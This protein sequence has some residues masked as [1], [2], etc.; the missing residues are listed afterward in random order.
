[1]VLTRDVITQYFST[2][3]SLADGNVLSKEGVAALADW[4]ERQD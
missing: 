1:M 3:I 2:L 4:S